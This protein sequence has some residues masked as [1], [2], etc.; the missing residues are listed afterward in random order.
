ML[1][2]SCLLSPPPAMTETREPAETGGYASLEEDEENLSP[3]EVAL[4]AAVLTK[5]LSWAWISLG[6]CDEKWALVLL[7]LFRLRL[8]AL[9]GLGGAAAWVGSGSWLEAGCCLRALSL[10]WAPEWPSS[11][12]LLE[13][14]R[15]SSPG[16]LERLRVLFLVVFLER[17]RA[18]GALGLLDWLCLLWL[19]SSLDRERP[20]ALFL[21]PADWL[22]S[23]SLVL[24][25]HPRLLLSLEL[26]DHTPLLSLREADLRSWPCPWL[27]GEDLLC[28]MWVGVARRVRLL[29][30]L[31]FLFQL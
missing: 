21:E 5:L 20:P 13:Q 22:C 8:L 27:C 24:P 12:M 28:L 30:L 2:C 4:E 1:L 18:A 6:S 16:I 29:A 7:A 25:D 31:R 11:L 3:G 10:L 9:V 17:L 14:P 23:L 19:R 26:L 15:R